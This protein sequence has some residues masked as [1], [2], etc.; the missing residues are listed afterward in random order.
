MKNHVRIIGGKWRGRKI[1]FPNQDM[2][3]PTHDRIRETLFNWLEPY[4]SG[5]NCLDLFAGSGVI[6]FEAVSRGAATAV[7]VDNDDDVLKHLQR[8]KKTLSADN[9]EVMRARI[10]EDELN[11]PLDHFDI[12]FLDPPFY[13][14]LLSPTCHW[15]TERA[16]IRAGSIIYLESEINYQKINLPESWETLKSKR[17]ATVIYSLVEV[18]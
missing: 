9:V 8:N 10:P 17:T 6:G 12:V 3:R 11:F 15:L 13:Q 14:N 18:K 7:L 2:L 5:S 16:Y 4:L 1:V